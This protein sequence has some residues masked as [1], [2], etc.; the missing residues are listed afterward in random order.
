MTPHARAKELAASRLERAMRRAIATWALLFSACGAA[1]V[2][3]AAPPRATR[4]VAVTGERSDALGRAVAEE[5]GQVRVELHEGPAIWVPAGI[6]RE[7]AL[8]AG[9][10]IVVA[11][12]AG[13]AFA[14]VVE[15]IDR[16]V[17]VE[18]AGARE[19]LA[20]ERVVAM[21]H[22]G[23]VP[24]TTEVLPPPPEAPP[25]D[26]R[27][28]V[29]LATG[30]ELLERVELASC[31][32]RGARIRVAGGVPVPVDV[33]RLRAVRI[34]AGTMVHSLWEGGASSYLGVVDQTR[35]PQAHVTYEDGSEEWADASAI[36]RVERA[37]SA[38][39]GCPRGG[40]GPLSVAMMRVGEV[41]A[42]GRVVSCS[43]ESAMVVIGDAAPVSMPVQ[44]LRALAFAEG[45]RAR[46]R[47]QGGA[48]FM[49]TLGR[50][51]DGP[52]TVSATYEDGSVEEAPLA[53]IAWVASEDAAAPWACP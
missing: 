12:S 5:A 29:S 32:A 25:V 22:S 19:M 24:A 10:Q 14:T 20:I 23:V 40:G 4:L 9:Q 44:E 47:W 7:G 34:G 45:T 50:I 43:A 15:V 18:R 37:S 42:V 30:R 41:R 51:A 8:L 38:A 46:V 53:N 16:V 26:A 6:V 1:A 13:L 3:A 36:V 17:V 48:P 31:D 21:L 2:P 27:M 52:H 39:S 28:L 33:A 11:T 35:G 49:A